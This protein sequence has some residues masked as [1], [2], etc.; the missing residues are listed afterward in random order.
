MLFSAY[1][2]LE[3]LPDSIKEQNGIKTGASIPRYDLTKMAGSLPGIEDI[4]NKKGQVVMYLQECRGI[5]NSTAGRQAD[6]F[7]MAK[8]SLNFSSIYLLN[9][10]TEGAPFVGFGQFPKTETY[11]R[12]CWPN[13]FYE[14]RQDGLIFLISRDWQ[15][16]EVLVSLAGRYIAAGEAGMVQRGEMAEAIDSIRES[17]QTFY[18]YGEQMPKLW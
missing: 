15:R 6:C 5:I 10:T 8:N 9:R 12:D 17:A 14:S 16:I 13:P 3:Q 1:L 2:C 11:G 18:P 4:A 7:L